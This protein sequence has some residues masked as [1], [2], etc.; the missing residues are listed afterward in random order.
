LL[1]RQS[2]TKPYLEGSLLGDERKRWPPLADG[3]SLFPKIVAAGRSRR[4]VEFVAAEATRTKI[5]RKTK[6]KR[7]KEGNRERER[8]RE[9]ESR[10][11]MM[12]HYYALRCAQPADRL[13]LKSGV[14]RGARGKGWRG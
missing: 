11:R 14:K 10:R 9:R 8:E 2:V 5:E 3:G 12:M 13:M 4:T 7:E 6:K 1:F